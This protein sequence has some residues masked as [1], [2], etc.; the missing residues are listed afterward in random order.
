MAADFM[1]S[2]MVAESHSKLAPA[3]I[4][5]AE[6]DPLSSEGI[7]Y[8]ERLTQAG[9]PSCL[10]IYKGQGHTFAHWDG[11]DI[12]GSLDFVQRSKDALKKAYRCP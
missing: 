1:A 10:T 5:V 3:S 7:A 9:T 2:P 6:I 12:Q 4:H 8:H 11:G